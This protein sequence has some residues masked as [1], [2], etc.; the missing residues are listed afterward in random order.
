MVGSDAQ[1]LGGQQADQGPC[2]QLFHWGLE[3]VVE[4]LLYLGLYELPL[5]VAEYGDLAQVL[6]HA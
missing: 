3:G 4:D 5:L 6:C 2:V 1:A